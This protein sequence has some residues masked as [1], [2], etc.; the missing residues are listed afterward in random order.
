M[1]IC[2]DPRAQY[3]LHRAEIDAAIRSVLDGGRYI[4]GDSCL[5]F[6][7]EFS[8]YIGVGHGVGV[9]NGT[10]AIRIALEGLG[11]G[12]GDEVITVSH[13]AVATV[14]AIEQTGA[15]PVFVDIEPDYFTMDPRLLEK[16]I[17]GKTKAI[18]PVH[19]YGQG[20]DIEA[21]MKLAKKHDLFV[22]EDC[23]QAHGATLNGRRVGSFGDAACFSFYP[24]KNLG[25][26]GDGGMV[27]T[28]NAELAKKMR[29]IREYG[30]EERFISKLAGENSR[31]DELQAAVLLVKL[32][33]L[34]QDN[35]S[36]NKIAEHYQNDLR[37]LDIAFPKIRK[38]A[39]HVHHL[40]V[41]ETTK[42]DLLQKHLRENGIQA[43]V[44]YPMPIHLQPAYRG[45]VHSAG[46]LTVT[47][48]KVRTILSLPLYPGL[49][50]AD[51]KATVEAVKS[52][53]AT[54]LVS[55]PR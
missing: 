1:I 4:H 43:P 31:L 15:T 23:A 46:P 28:S 47:E 19:I 11:V 51:L 26:L 27:V 38:N 2:A 39:T 17:T 21:I 49:P 18:V 45:R 41:I 22:V 6:E 33:Y 42:R 52:F 5:K 16:A 44:H 3:E 10:D 32:R 37:D 29:L 30:W 48:Q 7:K 35:A 8:A 20:A 34:D 24:T 36:R 9:N 25:A 40:F 54:S 13:T 55:E 14:A 53:F 12:E 50:E